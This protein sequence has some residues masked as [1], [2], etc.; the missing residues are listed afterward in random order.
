MGVKLALRASAAK[1]RTT[2]TVTTIDCF[3]ITASLA[4]EFPPAAFLSMPPGPA[5]YD[6]LTGC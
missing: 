5:L 2:K 1:I 4:V 3:R 6:C